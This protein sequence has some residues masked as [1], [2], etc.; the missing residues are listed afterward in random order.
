MTGHYLVGILSWVNKRFKNCIVNLG[1]TL[2]RHNLRYS[3]PSEEHAY[4]TAHEMGEKWISENKKSLDILNIPYTLIRSHDWIS[5]PSFLPIHEELWSFYYKDIYFRNS[6]QEDIE[7]FIARKSDLPS[8]AVQS[9]SL[10]YLIEEAAA[11]ILLGQQQG[12]THLY[13]GKWHNCYFHLMQ[14][15]NE[16]PLILRG[17]EKCAFKRISP[18][19]I[20]N[21]SNTNNT[22][23][24]LLSKTA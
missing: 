7:G 9:M 21:S 16:L 5:S 19:K 11:D 4:M 17:L 2:H 18:A 6:V 15:T 22:Q 20:L 1:D 8:S 23:N 10:S 24:I 14:R 12:A 3:S 13:P